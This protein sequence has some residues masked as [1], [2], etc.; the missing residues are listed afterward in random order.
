MGLCK[1]NLHV[2]QFYVLKNF[3]NY[4]S[5]YFF[6]YVQQYHLSLIVKNP[7]APRCSMLLC[8]LCDP[9]ITLHTFELVLNRT[10]L[11]RN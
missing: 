4:E 6:I 1:V 5:L 3:A 11:D 10:C 2:H 7:T 8:A 9:N